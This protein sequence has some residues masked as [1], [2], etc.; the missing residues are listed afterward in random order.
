MDAM[1]AEELAGCLHAWRDRLKPADVGLPSGAGRRAPGLR[2]EEVAMLAGLSVDY[3]AR[4]EQGRASHPS[5]SV[6]EPLARTLRLTDAERAHLFRV[7]GQSMPDRARI[8]RPG[9]ARAPDDRGARTAVLRLSLRRADRRG[10]RPRRD[11][12]HAGF[13]DRGGT[14]RLIGHVPDA[15]LLPADEVELPVGRQRPVP[16]LVAVLEVKGN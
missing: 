8:D 15:S 3:L 16:R 5:P 14:R 12:R 4:L 6:H 9:R 13:T 1:D 10:L 11:E 2:R 7:A